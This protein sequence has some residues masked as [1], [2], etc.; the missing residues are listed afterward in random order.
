[1]KFIN[2]ASSLFIA[3][4]AVLAA[5]LAVWK[6]TDLDKG[7][8]TNLCG[9]QI[10]ACQNN[11]GGPDQALMAF[12]NADTMGWG[13]GCKSNKPT[14]EAWDWP[15]PA[16]DCTGSLAIC[17][18]NCGSEA[19]DRNKCFANCTASHKCN[20]EDAPVS[21]TNTTD[22]KVT[23]AYVGPAVSY[24][25]A[26]LGDLNDG[27]DRSNIGSS[28]SEAN[29]GKDNDNNSST[30]ISSDAGSLFKSAGITLFAIAAAV[31]VSAF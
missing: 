9:R 10:L 24:K 23:P 14:F 7:E 5:D 25:G 16:R 21:Y 26:D 18:E 17:Q 27:N 8:R 28:S 15:V 22:V 12:C 11:C 13:C 19:G 3:A 6:I 4:S 29:E 20:T 1:M 30:E 31:G 2:T